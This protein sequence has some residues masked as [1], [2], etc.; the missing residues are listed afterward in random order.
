MTVRLM[1]E[2]DKIQLRKIHDEFYSKEFPFS[3]FDNFLSA[4]V[5][6]DNGKV[7]VGGGI[8]PIAES[9][10]LT[11]KSFNIKEKREALY[12]MLQCQLFAATR[13]KYQHLHAFVQDESWQHCL[14]KIGFHSPKGK[15]LI[16]EV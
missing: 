10:I 9:I 8:K 6:E 7:V 1:T 3:H 5:I 14:E 2:E 15:C 12:N 11:D 4:F 16:L 13:L